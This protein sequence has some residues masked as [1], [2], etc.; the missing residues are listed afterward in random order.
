MLP[1]QE[2]LSLIDRYTQDSSYQALHWEGAFGDYV[3]IVH[4][5]PEVL[6]DSFQRVYGL[7]ILRD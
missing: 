1:Q 4:A 3:R 5:H 7:I 6:R 2:I